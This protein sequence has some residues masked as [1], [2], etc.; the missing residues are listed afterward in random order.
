ML[1]RA[2]AVGVNPFNLKYAASL[3]GLFVG[4]VAARQHPGLIGRKH[5]RIGLQNQTGSVVRTL[6]DDCHIL[7]ME[8][9]RG[10]LDRHMECFRERFSGRQLPH[11]AV[12]VVPAYRYTCL[13]PGS[14]RNEP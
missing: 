14:M 3:P 2:V 13:W 9:A 7:N 6:D 10:I 1:M 4:N 12:A 8:R 5:M 11:I